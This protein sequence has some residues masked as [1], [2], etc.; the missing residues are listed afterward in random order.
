MDISQDFTKSKD[1]RYYIA[2]E[3]KGPE[4]FWRVWCKT[5]RQD[6]SQGVHIVKH[7][8]MVGLRV[9]QRDVVS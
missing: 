1:H 2:K 5:E 4:T 7:E 3:P 6:G 8:K 9:S